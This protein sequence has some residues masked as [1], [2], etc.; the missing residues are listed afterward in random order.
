MTERQNHTFP[1]RPLRAKSSR[2]NN[3]TSNRLPCQPAPTCKQGN[4][5]WRV[6][7]GEHGQVLVLDDGGPVGGQAALLQTGEQVVEVHAATH[8][9]R[10]SGTPSGPSGRPPARGGPAAPTTRRE[11]THVKVGVHTSPRQIASTAAAPRAN[12][13]TSWSDAFTSLMF[14]SSR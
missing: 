14:L 12:G 2:N 10:R 3:I 13:D 1:Q 6:Y 9:R 5:K 8:R 11:N 7:L 4:R